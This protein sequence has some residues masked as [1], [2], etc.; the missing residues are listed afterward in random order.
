MGKTANKLSQDNQHEVLIKEL[1][2]K[3]KI[4]LL[5][6]HEFCYSLVAANSIQKEH[7]RCID[8]DI[9]V[10]PCTGTEA[11]YRPYGP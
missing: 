8:L 6:N 3:R 7:I 4:F 2:N 9:N 11:L 5:V 10:H 1:W